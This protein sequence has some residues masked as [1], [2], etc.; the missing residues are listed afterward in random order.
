MIT[1]V[2]VVA[3][4][5]LAIGNTEETLTTPCGVEL[6]IITE[7]L[8]LEPGKTCA[9]PY[10]ITTKEQQPVENA[11]LRGDVLLHHHHHPVDHERERVLTPITT[12]NINT[13]LL[14]H[15]ELR[16]HNTPRIIT[17]TL[18]WGI[19]LT[20]ILALDYHRLTICIKPPLNI[21]NNKLM[22]LTAVETQE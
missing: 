7:V 18:R 16:H 2:L 10:T 9:R 6:D 1:G 4:H 20:L 11:V 21:H 8:L 19:L 14:A 13:P 22:A 17:L 5:T 12:H 3:L 15:L